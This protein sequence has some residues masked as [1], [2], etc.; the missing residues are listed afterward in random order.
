M[1]WA[2]EIASHAFYLYKHHPPHHLCFGGIPHYETITPDCR[3]VRDD[4]RINGY[5]NLD[6]E[7]QLLMEKFK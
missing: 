3:R 5:Y 2:A 4:L 1:A 6:F 7:L